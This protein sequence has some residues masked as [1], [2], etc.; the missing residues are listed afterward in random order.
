M[1]AVLQA[2]ATE[3]GSGI[4]PVSFALEAEEIG[5][6]ASGRNGGQVVP[7]LKPDPVSLMQAIGAPLRDI[8]EVAAQ[9]ST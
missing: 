1:G 9:L 4:S 2:V 7:G 5:A 6:R 8:P 3:G